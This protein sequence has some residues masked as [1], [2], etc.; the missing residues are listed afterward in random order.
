M[1][2]LVPGQARQLFQ[3]EAA[4]GNYG[5]VT[6]LNPHSTD[7]PCNSVFGFFHTEQRNI[8]ETHKCLVYLFNLS[9]D[10]NSSVKFSGLSLPQPVSQPT[11]CL[12]V[13]LCLSCLSSILSLFCPV[14]SSS[15]SSSSSLSRSLAATHPLWAKGKQMA[16]SPRQHNA[17]AHIHKHGWTWCHQTP[18]SEQRHSVCVCATM[19]LH[20]S[21]ILGLILI[22]TSAL[23]ITAMTWFYQDIVSLSLF[24]Y[25]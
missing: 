25:L 23:T 4:Y 24:S 22:H 6:M 19:W 8:A 7:L 18:M 10:T 20:I 12:F 9:S 13:C 3:G 5:D 15:F 16:A 17:G 11:V 21:V 14:L 1:A 2:H